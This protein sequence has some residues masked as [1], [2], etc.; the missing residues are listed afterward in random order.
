VP[1]KQ[2]KGK[3]YGWPSPKEAKVTFWYKVSID[4]IGPYTISRVE[5]RDL[6]C[7]CITIINPE[8]AW[9]EVYQYDDKSPLQWLIY[10]SNAFPDT[11]G[12]LK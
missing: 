2:T 8:N 12:K 5:E 6:I 3:K 7:K 1:K 11:H 4:L 9:F 10:L